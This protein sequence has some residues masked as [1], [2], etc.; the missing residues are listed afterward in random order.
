T[1]TGILHGAGNLSDKLIENKTIDDFEYVFG[2]KII[3]LNNLLQVVPPAQLKNLILFS[4]AAGFYGNPGQADYA[5]ANEVLNKVAYYMQQNYPDCQVLS[6]N[7]GPWDAGMVNDELKKIFAERNISVIPVDV[8]TRVLIDQLEKSDPAVQVLVGDP[9]TNPVT[10]PDGDLRSYSIQ[11]NL[12]EAA[13]PFLQS[14][15]VG[16]HA[17]LPM[18]HALSWMASGC[19]DLY[20]GYVFVRSD[21]YRVFK[22]IV[23]D[24]QNSDTYTLEIQELKRETDEI[25]LKTMIASDNNG[26]KRFHYGAEIKLHPSAPDVPVFADFD[27]TERDPQPGAQYYRNGTLFHGKALQGIDRVL[28]ISDDRLTTHCTMPDIPLPMQGQFYVQAF[29]PYM[30][31]IALQSMLIYVRHYRDAASLPLEIKVVEQYRP[32][33]AGT[34]F[35]ST[36]LVTEFTDTALVAEFYIHDEQ[37]NLYLHSAGTTVTISKQMNELF[38]QSSKRNNP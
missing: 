20:P 17:V 11:R 12:D 1:I 10:L 35:Y 38:L 33:S 8:G 32:I 19:E 37:G 2:A 6:V 21:G 9:M 27:L 15:M 18:L 34:V 31:D 25:V 7:W 29:N 23:F 36:M 5:I 22:G 13:S 26:R 16:E 24:E 30:A 4:S 14:H 3:G 28:N